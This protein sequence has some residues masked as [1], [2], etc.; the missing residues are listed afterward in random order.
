MAKKRK[1]YNIK[2]SEKRG[3][4]GQENKILQYFWK[5]NTMDDIVSLSETEL[6]EL[7]DKNIETYKNNQ[8]AR[9]KFWWFP[10]A[11]MPPRQKR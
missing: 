4:V 1:P 7:I 6:D 10:D 11:S 3:K 9:N 5:Q 8:I 2:P